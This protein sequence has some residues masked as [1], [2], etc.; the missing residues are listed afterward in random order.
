MF[1]KSRD[2]NRGRYRFRNIRSEREELARPL[3]PQ[4]DGKETDKHLDEGV[5]P[6]YKKFA[7]IPQ[8]QCLFLEKIT[9][10]IRQ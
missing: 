5:F 3:R 4:H 1:Q 9:E 7:S 2:I 6:G 8:E 10:E